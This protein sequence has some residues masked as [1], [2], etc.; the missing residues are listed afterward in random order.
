M[1][2][3]PPQVQRG[4]DSI[5]R[6]MIEL[7]AS[8]AAESAKLATLRDYLLPRLLSGRVRVRDAEAVAEGVTA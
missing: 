3:A 8:S 4:F 5:V 6:P 1:L 2:V 7:I